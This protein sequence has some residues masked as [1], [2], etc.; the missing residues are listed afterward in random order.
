MRQILFRG[1]R[2][3]N[4]EWIEGGVYYFDGSPERMDESWIYALNL[5]E[6]N[7]Y[8]LTGFPVNPNTVGQYTGLTDKNGAKIFE[9]DKVVFLATTCYVLNDGHY[10]GKKYEKGAEFFIKWL[11]SGFTLSEFSEHVKDSVIPNQ[12]GH[13]GNYI[14]WNNARSFEI[15]GNIHD[16]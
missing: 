8:R 7:V 11:P 5:D 16:K 12:I 4:G 13:V 14:L 15:T 6:N 1:K 10:C 9:G 3:D 2:V